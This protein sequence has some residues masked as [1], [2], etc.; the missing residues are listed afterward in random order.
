MNISAVFKF[1]I[2]FLQKIIRYSHL[3]MIANIC[4]FLSAFLLLM[5]F[6]PRDLFPG[7]ENQKTAF[8]K[9]KSDK[10]IL[11]DLP[12]G[13]NITSENAGMSII[14]DKESFLI[15]KKMMQEYSPISKEIDWNLTIGIG[16]SILYAPVGNYKIAAF[17]PIYVVEMPSDDRSS[18]LVLKPIGQLEEFEKWFLTQHND[19]VNLVAILLLIFG[20]G[21]QL[22]IELGVIGVKI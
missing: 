17:R 6:T 3:G 2:E 1:L 12:K 22:L 20:F 19:S 16:Y 8:L 11:G 14:Q 5:N 7:Y 21:I 4:L 9:L 13:I 18:T 10:N 15:I